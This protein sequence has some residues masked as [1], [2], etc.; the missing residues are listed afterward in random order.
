VRI[1]NMNLSIPQITN[2][3]G[4]RL[5]PGDKSISHRALMIGAIADGVSEISYCSR[6]ADPMS[7]LSCIKQLGLKIDDLGN[8][9][10][11]YGNGR[12]GLK[13]PSIPLDA[14]NSG[15]TMRLLSGILAGQHYSSVIIGDPSLSQRPMKRIFDPLRLMGAQIHGTVKDTA[16]IHIEPV[17]RLH[18]I[19]YVLPVPSA[20]VKSSLLFA[21]LFA[22]TTTSIIE[23]TQTRDHT[24]RMLGLQT[25]KENGSFVV[26]VH[27]DLKIEGKRFFVP[28]DMSAAAF[29]L[30]AGLIIPGSNIRIQ[31]IGLNPTRRRI[32]DIFRSMGG[33]ILIDNER[34]IEGEMIGDLLVQYSNLKSNLE[35]R[36]AEVV[37]LIDEIPIL[38]VTALF[39]EGSF[40]IHDAQELRK[41]ETDR[42][43]AIVNN[44]RLLGCE[45][46]EYED[47]FAFEGNKTYSGNVLPS[48]G[49]HRIAMAFAIAGARIQ[50]VTI[51][52]TECVDI[53]F[54]DFWKELL[55]NVK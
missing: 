40:R 22:D 19:R 9:I 31:N 25:K 15:T 14:G 38:S 2:L 3:Q 32:L 39:A 17:D 34:T 11:I 5:V 16:P 21:G 45:V 12:R 7:T 27:P 37:D 13:M 53:S 6:A 24:E 41:K 23:K 42:I 55:A 43:S 28:G 51:T 35:L 20:Q 33:T 50:N 18:A 8:Q 36:G 46:E 29:L 30:S 52:D 44:L 48:Y 47:G 10:V 49:D 54:P 4:T 26:D 1:V